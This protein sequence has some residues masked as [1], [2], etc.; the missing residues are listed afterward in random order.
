MM[1]MKT[2][3][4]AFL[5]CRRYHISPTAAEITLP[6]TSPPPPFS[7][8]LQ[9]HGKDENPKVQTFSK[10]AKKTIGDYSSTKRTKMSASLA[11]CRYC[12]QLPSFL[13]S[14]LVLK[15]LI[16]IMEVC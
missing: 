13:V 6:P 8:L 9:S 15:V 3:P 4:P 10:R 11:S 14:Q 5:A 2:P 1:R 16:S 7:T 12:A